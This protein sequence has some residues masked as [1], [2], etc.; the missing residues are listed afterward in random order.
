MTIQHRPEVL[1]PA[2]DM[3]R[4]IAAVK[5]GADAVYLGGSSFGMRANAGNFDDEELREG[6]AYAHDHGVRVY[7]TCNTLP[8]NA[9]A[10][11]LEGFLLRAAQAGVDA[12]IVADVGVLMLARRVVPQIDV[13]ISTQTGVVNYLTANALYQLGARRVVLARE[14]SLDAIREIR[15]RTPGG[16]GDRVLCPRGDV[17]VLLRALPALQLPH[18]PGR[19]P[20]GVRPALPLE[21]LPDGGKAP[22]AVFPH[23]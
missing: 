10:D 8:T 22:G 18:R 7:L 12:L 9:E 1:A 17:Y 16:P 13:H 21:L 23:L 5:Y 11:A 20:G 2:G 19:Q 6:V 4:L 14:L 3:E 15:R